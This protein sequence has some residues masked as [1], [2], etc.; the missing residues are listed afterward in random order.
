MIIKYT[1]RGNPEAHKA[2]VDDKVCTILDGVKGVKTA[3]D[4]SGDRYI[5]IA[6]YDP[7]RPEMHLLITTPVYVMNDNGK[8]IEV[9]NPNKLSN[10]AEYKLTN[11][12][13]YHELMSDCEACAL[14]L[15]KTCPKKLWKDWTAEEINTAYDIITKTK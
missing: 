14:E 5:T 11:I 8:T 13:T 6:F 2:G 4:A 9:I 7:F 12:K 15:G 10:Y 1:L 3:L